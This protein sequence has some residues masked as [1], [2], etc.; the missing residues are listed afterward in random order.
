AASDSQSPLTACTWSPWLIQTTVSFGTPANRPS[1]SRTRQWARPNSRLGA[2][3]T[4]PPKVWQASRM[5][6]PD[7]GTG[8]P[9]ANKGGIAV[10]SAWRI[11]TRRPTGEDEASR[12]QLGDA[13]GR[14][15]VAHDLAEDVLLAHAPGDELAVLR[16]EVE[17]QDAFTFGQRWHLA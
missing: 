1:A 4:S 7:P 11:D 2:G 17:D 5:P 9:Q 14:Q 12:L 8:T 13:R 6:E 10:G 15:I 3:L 16:A